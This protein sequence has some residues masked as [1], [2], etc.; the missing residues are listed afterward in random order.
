MAVALSLMRVVSRYGV[1]TAS[2]MRMLICSITMSMCVWTVL[3]TCITTYDNCQHDDIH[4][5]TNWKKHCHSSASVALAIT[6]THP[7]TGAP[8]F[9]TTVNYE[10]SNNSFNITNAILIS[11]PAPFDHRGCDRFPERLLSNT[12]TSMITSIHAPNRTVWFL[13]TSEG[14]DLR[15][16]IRFCDRFP[17]YVQRCD[18][19]VTGALNGLEAGL[20]TNVPLLPFEDE[21]MCISN[22]IMLVC[23][24]RDICGSVY[25]V[26]SV[27]IY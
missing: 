19:V 20:V 7:V 4:S 12:N 26:I 25:E 15:R 16:K 21:S 10:R 17:S 1:L 18:G 13:I 24:S 3:L 23:C 9:W 2:V 8:I 6:V 11:V 22:D 14:C 27:C 5:C